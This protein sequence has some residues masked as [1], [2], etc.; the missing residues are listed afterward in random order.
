MVQG[1]SFTYI[2]YEGTTASTK[3]EPATPAKEIDHEDTKMP[4]TSEVS[5]SEKKILEEAVKN[6]TKDKRHLFT[7][8]P[9][10][11]NHWE[12]H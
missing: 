3:E 9:E 7:D 10:F 2:P 8:H 5:E 12:Q 6:M 11:L 4:A 1:D